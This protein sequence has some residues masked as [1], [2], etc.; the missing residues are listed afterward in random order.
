MCHQQ[1]A[2]GVCEEGA[3]FQVQAIVPG[4]NYEW[5]KSS[6]RW[7]WE[8]TPVTTNYHKPQNPRPANYQQAYRNVPQQSQIHQQPWPKPTNPHKAYKSYKNPLRHYAKNYIPPKQQ[9]K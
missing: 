4:H 6:R 5:N 1:W 8:K 2:P 7:L 9:R 3:I